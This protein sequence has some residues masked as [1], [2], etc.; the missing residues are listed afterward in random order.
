MP[1]PPPSP[2]S[3]SR[4]CARNFPAFFSFPPGFLP[5]R[6]GRFRRRLVVVV[7]VES[8]TSISTSPAFPAVARPAPVSVVTWSAL[9][10]LG[11]GSV[12]LAPRLATSASSTPQSVESVD[13]ALIC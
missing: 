12:S 10:R 8:S 5:G 11:P 9:C 1:A 7:S 2:L 3:W 6:F 13:L 4:R